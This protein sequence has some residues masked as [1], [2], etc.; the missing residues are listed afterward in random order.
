MTSSSAAQAGSEGS[1]LPAEYSSRYHQQFVDRLWMRGLGATVGVYLVGVLIYFAW[2]QFALMGTSKV[3]Q[4]AANLGPTYTNALQFKARLQILKDRQD[5]KYAA[6]DCWKVVA[7]L[8]PEGMQLEGF[9]FSDGKRLTINGTAPVGQEKQLLE[10]EKA[11]RKAVVNNQ[12][13]F[14]T[15]ADPVDQMKWDP[16]RGNVEEWRCAFTLKRSETL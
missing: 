11:L 14:E 2:L 1:L 9:H 4:D 13:I 7:E 12:P 15:F 5:L 10:F 6:L 3:E 8:L 16:P